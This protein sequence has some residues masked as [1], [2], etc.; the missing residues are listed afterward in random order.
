MD[1]F[2]GDT[3][4]NFCNEKDSVIELEQVSEKDC[5]MALQTLKDYF[6]K[7]HVNLDAITGLN[8]ISKALT[9]ERSKFRMDNWL[10]KKNIC[11]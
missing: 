3:N 7:K 8:L 5:Y 11:E 9:K 4:I 10:I 2:E 1:D 6:N